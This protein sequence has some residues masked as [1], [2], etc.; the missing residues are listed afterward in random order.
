MKETTPTTT[1]HWGQWD[2][3]GPT[4]LSPGT[5]GTRARPP[6]PGAAQTFTEKRQ[7]R[8]VGQ[9]VQNISFYLLYLQQSTFCCMQY[10]YSYN[11]LLRR[12]IAPWTLTHPPS[13][14]M[15]GQDRGHSNVGGKGS[16][17]TACLA[18][19]CCCCLWDML[20]SGH[21]WI[22][23]HAAGPSGPCTWCWETNYWDNMLYINNM[24]YDLNLTPESLYVQLS[25]WPLWE[26][27]FVVRDPPVQRVHVFYTC[28]YVSSLFFMMT[29]SRKSFLYMSLIH[30][31]L[32]LVLSVFLP[33][34]EIKI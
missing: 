27:V 33:I 34:W 6:T 31:H 20:A 3:R 15:V 12:D 25:D 24:F 1:G 32:W 21:H 10:S 7:N 9:R 18:A 19:L 14:F 17:L 28:L 5:R 30:H 26:T 11:K 13:V 2:P 4:C 16:C 8:Q 29:R 23:H 22:S